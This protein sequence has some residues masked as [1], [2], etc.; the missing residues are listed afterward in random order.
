ML[1]GLHAAATEPLRR[2]RKVCTLVSYGRVAG[3]TTLVETGTY[4]G[5]TIAGCRRSFE[6]IYSIELDRPLHEQAQRRFAAESA[7]TLILGDSCEELTR[8][9]PRIE[10]PALFWLDAHWSAGATAK[11]PHDPP[12]EWEL[13][14][15]LARREA[16]VVLID[17]ARLLGVERGWP[18]LDDLRRLVGRRAA[19]FEVRDDIVRIRL[20]GG[21]RP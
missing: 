5:H 11:G 15:I 13:R 1:R 20:T 16:D 2:R 3:L 17:D 9:A 7:V 8:L 12:I 21:G 18:S 19:T 4:K 10:G 6:R 14:A